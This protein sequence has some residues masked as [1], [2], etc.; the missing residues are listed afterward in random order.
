MDQHISH[1]CRSA[2]LAMRQ[3]ASI[4]RY[5]TEK[6]KH[7]HF[8]LF[9]LNYYNAT[10]ASLPAALLHASR[11]YKTMQPDLSF[12]SQKSMSH[13]FP[14]NYTGFRIKHVLT[15]NWQHLLFDTLMVLCLSIS[16][17][18]LTYISHPD[19]LDQ[20]M[21]G[22]SGFHV[23]NW[24]LSGTGLSATKDLLFGT[25]FPLISNSYL[26]WPPLK[27]IQDTNTFVQEVLF[28]LLR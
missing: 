9:R 1:L 11:E 8:V 16:L 17:Q 6:K 21:T 23:G 20:T 3:T 22:F 24:N 27:K 18:R 10:F 25:L 13:C 19:R 14:K 7:S 26:P 15:T 12:K 28:T 4:R 2:Y 5:L